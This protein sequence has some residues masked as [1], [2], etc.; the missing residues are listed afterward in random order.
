MVALVVPLWVDLWMGLVA[1][2]G[3]N[4]R[5]GS[6][7]QVVACRGACACLV[8]DLAFLFVTE[9]TIITPAPMA[10]AL[11]ALDNPEVSGSNAAEDAHPE[12]ED[13]V[14]PGAAAVALALRAASRAEDGLRVP[15]LLSDRVLGQPRDR[16]LHTHRIPHRVVY[17]AA[18]ASVEGRRA[19]LSAMPP[20]QRAACGAR[21]PATASPTPMGLGPRL[22]LLGR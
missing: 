5:P 3:R 7:L 14:A 20:Q 12:R 19:E 8:P 10:D 13:A 16:H 2:F 22:H 1:S 15:S 9:G 17:A 4:H 21:Q 11:A 18:P 6:D